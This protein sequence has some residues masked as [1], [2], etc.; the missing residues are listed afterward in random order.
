VDDN[1]LML[2]VPKGDVKKRQIL[3]HVIEEEKQMFIPLSLERFVCVAFMGLIIQCFD[4]FF[5]PRGK[6]LKPVKWCYFFRKVLSYTIL[7]HQ[8]FGRFA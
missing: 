1:V 7:T 5:C 2:K 8:P 3:E 6:L 4:G